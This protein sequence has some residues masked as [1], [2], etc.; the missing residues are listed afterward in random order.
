MKKYLAAMIL[1]I[2]SVSFAACGTNEEKQTE[3]AE[4]A[5]ETTDTVFSEEKTDHEMPVVGNIA[6]YSDNWYLDGD[7]N[8]TC[9]RI[10][11]TS[12]WEM[13]SADAMVSGTVDVNENET[14]LLFLNENEEVVAEVYTAND[15]DLHVDVKNT[16]FMQLPEHCH[17]VREINCQ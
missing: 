11:E 8:N 12:T 4:T 2:A 1:T 5:V 14:A 7:L 3:Q 15:D 10:E 9:I 13:S 17:F 16:E 6:F